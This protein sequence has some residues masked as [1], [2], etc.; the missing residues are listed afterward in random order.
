MRCG[1]AQVMAF[2]ENGRSRKRRMAR[3]LNSLYKRDGIAAFHNVHVKKS[4]KTKIER[5]VHND[6]EKYNHKPQTPPF[7]KSCPIHQA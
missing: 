4:R 5:S 3:V 2:T 6:Y 1:L 7:A